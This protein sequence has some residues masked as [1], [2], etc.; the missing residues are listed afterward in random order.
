MCF[1]PQAS[2]PH[3]HV[4]VSDLTNADDDDDLIAGNH[5]IFN[6]GLDHLKSQ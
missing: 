4:L 5:Q 6:S 3:A 2:T 1:V